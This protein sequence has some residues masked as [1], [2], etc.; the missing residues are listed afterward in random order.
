MN[1]KIYA[2][3]IPTSSTGKTKYTYLYLYHA[4]PINRREQ[5]IKKP[6]FKEITAINSLW[7]SWVFTAIIHKTNVDNILL[8]SFPHS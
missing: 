5:L 8:S 6:V 2:R 4:I 7:I 3:F 1:T